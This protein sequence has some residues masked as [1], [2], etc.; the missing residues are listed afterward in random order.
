MVGQSPCSLPPHAGERRSLE[1]VGSGA[2]EAT[3][4]AEPS[5]APLSVGT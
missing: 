5:K 1:G 3:G 4:T 2:D